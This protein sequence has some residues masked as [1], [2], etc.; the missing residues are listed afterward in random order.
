MRQIG[1]KEHAQNNRENPARGLEYQLHS[2][3]STIFWECKGRKAQGSILGLEI[4]G[5]STTRSTETSSSCSLG[6][7]LSTIFSLS[8]LKPS[9][10]FAEISMKGRSPAIPSLCF[11]SSLGVAS[12]LFKMTT[13]LVGSMCSWSRTC[14]ELEYLISMFSIGSLASSKSKMRSA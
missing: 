6:Y 8:F 13:I 14:L 11:N 1:E 10:V 12:S 2:H 3:V 9:P 5:D 4:S 7:T